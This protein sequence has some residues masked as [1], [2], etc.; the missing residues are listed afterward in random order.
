LIMLALMI[1][2]EWMQRTKQHGLEIAHLN[3]PLRWAIYLPLVFLVVSMSGER[4]SFIY[5]QF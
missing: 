2:G 3:R 4:V 5:F 1:F